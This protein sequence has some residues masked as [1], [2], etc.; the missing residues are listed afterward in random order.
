M[1][2]LPDQRGP[3]QDHGERGDLVDEGDDGAEPGGV[4]VGIE[5]FADDDAEGELGLRVRAVDERVD[6]IAEDVLD[7]A[8]TDARLL[9]CGGVHGHLHLGGPAAAKVE[10]RTGSEWRR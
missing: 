7:I 6:A 1:L 9:H 4:A 3:G 5:L 8:G 2:P 10:I